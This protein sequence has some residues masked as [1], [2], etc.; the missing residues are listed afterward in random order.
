[1]HHEGGELCGALGLAQ[2]LRLGLW[3]LPHGSTGHITHPFVRLLHGVSHHLR[4]PNKTRKMSRIKGNIPA[5]EQEVNRERT[6]TEQ[7]G[8]MSNLKQQEQYSPARRV[9]SIDRLRQKHRPQLQRLRAARQRRCALGCHRHG[10]VN[11]HAA[12]FAAQIQPHTVLAG[13]IDHG[14]AVGQLG[15]DGTPQES[16]LNNVPLFLDACVKKWWLVRKISNSTVSMFEVH[17][18]LYKR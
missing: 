13:G 8:H 12:P 16:V 11:I 3:L 14:F 17:C 7:K 2:S 4:V 9:D 1:M 15:V 5:R 10:V 6:E 18:T